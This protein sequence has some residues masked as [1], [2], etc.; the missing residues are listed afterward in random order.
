[1]LQHVVK[2][3]TILTCTKCH[4]QYKAADGFYTSK[5]TSNG[6]RCHCKSCEK[7]DK[8]AEHRK[9]CAYCGKTKK[10]KEFSVNSKMPSGRQAYCRD[11][12][13]VYYAKLQN[14]K[15]VVRAAAKPIKTA[16]VAKSKASNIHVHIFIITDKE[17]KHGHCR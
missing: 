10:L 11:C 8:R 14:S 2:P 4:N 12:Y 9:K 15:A 13:R 5:H 3:D 1:M 16:K 17:L 7:K 6:Y